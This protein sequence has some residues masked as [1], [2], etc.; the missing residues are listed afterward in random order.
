MHVDEKGVECKNSARNSK[1]ETG[2]V[3]KCCVHGGDDRCE[4][5]CYTPFSNPS[6]ANFTHPDEGREDKM[7]AAFARDMVINKRIEGNEAEAVRLEKN[8]GF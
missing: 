2:K 6:W 1:H 4:Q 5:M 3:D 7:C 8:F